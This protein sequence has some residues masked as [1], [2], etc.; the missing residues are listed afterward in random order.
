MSASLAV[1]MESKGMLLISSY[2]QKEGEEKALE[3]YTNI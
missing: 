1:N 2:L 3:N